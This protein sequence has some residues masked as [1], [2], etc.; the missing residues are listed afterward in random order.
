M[1]HSNGLHFKKFDLHVHTPATKEFKDRNVKPDDII[2]KAINEGL[3]GI[4]ITDHQTGEWID[5]IK[6]AAKD[7]ELV[8]FPGV[9]LKATGG[10][11]GIHLIILFDVDKNTQHISNFLVQ[12]DV[13]KQKNKNRTVTDYSVPHVAKKL[14]GFDPN[15]III[16]AHCHSDFGVCGDLRGEQRQN[17]FDSQ[18]NCILGAETSEANFL[19]QN[20]Q[21]KG[22][23]I[24]DLFNGCH[25]DYHY[26]KLGV[27][28]ASDARS[29]I[30]IGSKFTYFKVDSL[31]T[32]EDIKQSLLDRDTRIRQ[33]F[34]Y[35]KSIYPHIKS[36][37]ITS[38]FLSE[39]EFTFHEGLN[40]L[41][42]AKG[43]GKSLAVE[44]LRFCLNREPQ[45]K[46]I[47]NDH[48]SKLEKCLGVYGEVEISISD[49]SG[50]E[51]LIKRTYDPSESNPIV[52]T[53]S[54]EKTEQFFEI[55][56]LFPVLFLTDL[57]LAT[58][59]SSQL[60]LLNL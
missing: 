60:N 33:S 24:V 34:E 25:K 45:N 54:L 50:K 19:D 44:F 16:L 9:E 55:E 3:S 6:E 57:P 52:I 12:L 10:R 27:Y 7:K 59:P 38:G 58:R 47:N 21:K 32:L 42:G 31:I 39:Q 17:I 11:D 15:A 5:K 46:D 20:K 37:K 35:K 14:Q 13:S 40:S 56:Q 22:T 18:Y 29:I 4:A 8:I 48:K 36:L 41:L 2:E 49:D 1:A 43:S 30:D 26:K 53:D 23:R 51:Y 28:Q